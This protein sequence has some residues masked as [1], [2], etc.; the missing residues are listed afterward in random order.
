ALSASGRAHE[1][2]SIF[3]QALTL[4]P[5]DPPTLLNLAVALHRAERFTDAISAYQRVLA[6]QP[7]SVQAHQSLGRALQA[8]EQHQDAVACFGRALALAGGDAALRARLLHDRAGSLQALERIEAAHTD[9][10]EAHR[11]TP[12]HV[13]ILLDLT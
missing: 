9:L 4:A 6:L 7:A 1:A 8:T 10:Q 2:L 3:E 12:D 5:N 11:L 13:A